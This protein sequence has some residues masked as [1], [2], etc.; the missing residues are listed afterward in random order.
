MRISSLTSLAVFLEILKKIFN[1]ETEVLFRILRQ[2][3]YARNFMGG[4][5]D[6]HN[7]CVVGRYFQVTFNNIKKAGTVQLGVG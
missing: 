7:N 6:Q 5:V 1:A 3:L 4:V 2:K